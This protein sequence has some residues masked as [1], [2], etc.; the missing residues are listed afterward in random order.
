MSKSFMVAAAFLAI[1]C[2]GALAQG[3]SGTPDEQAAC[4]R[5]VNRHCK[6]V[7]DQGDLVIL[8]C[9]Q[10]NRPKISVGCKKVLESHG[11]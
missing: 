10:Q 7:I 1:T 11:Q 8:A 4:T 2:T 3:R 9:L 6:S 5:D